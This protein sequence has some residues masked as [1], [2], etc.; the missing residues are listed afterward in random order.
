VTS[1]SSPGLPGRADVSVRPAR[2]GD[3]AAIARVQLVTWRTAFRALL[4]ASVLDDW[5][6]PAAVE[7][8]RTAATSPPTPGHGLLVALDGAVVTGFAAYGPAE[9]SAGQESEPGRPTNELTAL[10]VEPRWGRRGHGS[11]LL[12][13]VADLSA[14]AGVLR[15]QM[16]VPADDAVTA[17]FLSGAGW[18]ADGWARTLDT[19]G[20]PLREH[21]WHTMLD[22]LAP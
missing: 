2:G 8:W 15:L 6:E 20:S 3:A 17:A 21:R 9:M 4:P 18:A 5:D 11:R 12:A 16:W 14:A 10:L 13:A 22:E 19:G 1:P 7:A